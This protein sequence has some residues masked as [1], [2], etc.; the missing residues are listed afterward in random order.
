LVDA[1]EKMALGI[2]IG[3]PL[4][5]RHEP[6]NQWDPNAVKVFWNDQWIG[7]IPKDMAA[8]IRQLELNR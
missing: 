3:D 2:A 7:Y 4:L 8:L 5:L 1:A 6:E